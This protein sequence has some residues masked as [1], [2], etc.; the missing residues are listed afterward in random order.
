MTITDQIRTASIQWTVVESAFQIW[1]HYNNIETRCLD[2][3]NVASTFFKYDSESNFR[4]FVIGIYALYDSRS[5]TSS[6][7]NINRN[8]SLELSNSNEIFNKIKKL[9]HKLFAHRDKFV[10]YDNVF[11]DVR[12]TANEIKSIIDFAYCDLKKLSEN[13]NCEGPVRSTMVS[14]ELTYLFNLIR[15]AKQQN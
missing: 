6:I 4:T 10:P 14:E 13:A 7:I 11:R 15:S 3:M 2:V 12:I 9:R 8:F 1:W 5:D